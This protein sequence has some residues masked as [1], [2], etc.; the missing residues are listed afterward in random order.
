MKFTLALISLVAV[1]TALP[2]APAQGAAS[3]AAQAVQASP[4]AAAKS[5]AAAAAQKQSPTPAALKPTT[6]KK[7]TATPTPPA[8][9]L[10][11]PSCGY[12]IINPLIEASGCEFTGKHLDYK[13]T[14]SRLIIANRSRL[15]LPQ[16]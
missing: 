9:F 12:N 2:G 16:D 8:P 5:P 4:A 11:I 6:T 13:A 15:L 7:V 1:A 3:P 14:E 10:A